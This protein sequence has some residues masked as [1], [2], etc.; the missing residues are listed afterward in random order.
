MHDTRGPLLDHCPPTLPRAA[1]VDQAWFDAER[2]AIW[3]REW[4]HV[5][6]LADLA[7]GHVWC[8]EVAG[9]P[10]VVALSGDG[11][12]AWHNVCRHRGAQLCARDGGTGTRLTCPYHAW[13]YALEDGRLLSTGFGTPTPDFDRAAH[14]LLP[15]AAQ[16]WNGFV[17][18][19]LADTPPAFAPDIGT[20][21]LDNWPMSTLKSGHS[22]TRDIACNW[23]VFWE[24]YNECLHCP[25]IHPALSSRVPVYA[26]GV[27]S[28]AEDARTDAAAPV[29]ARGARSWTVSGAPCG[30]EFSGL[31]AAER[32]EGH[33]FVTLYPTMFVVA[34]VDYV[35]TVTLT[36][37]TPTT[38]RLHVDWLFAP[39]TLAQADFDLRDVTDFATTVLEEDAAA[40]EVNQRG[41]A[42]PA[43]TSGTLM[44]QEFDVARF[45]DWIRAR[46]NAQTEETP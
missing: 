45:H 39:E 37:L 32:A 14:G 33:R 25:G 34:H 31:T 27:M 15:V 29:L 3:A 17:F 43:Y 40:C 41:I 11:A 18:V 26:R 35:R 1:Y 2:A 23:K 36:P 28:A 30:P 5:G 24:N 16:V 9:R 44:P 12:V 46:L 42:S 4:V 10:I 13:S 8:R 22:L 19:S 20:H 7:P 6:R 21:A 38:S